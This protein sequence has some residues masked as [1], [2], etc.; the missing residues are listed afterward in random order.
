MPGVGR[1]LI[2]NWT[3]FTQLDVKRTLKVAARFVQRKPE[4]MQRVFDKAEARKEASVA[5]YEAIQRLWKNQRR[6]NSYDL[7]FMD[8]VCEEVKRHEGTKNSQRLDNADFRVAVNDW[9][10]KAT[11]GSGKG[12]LAI[13]LKNRKTGGTRPALRVLEADLHELAKRDPKK[14]ETALK[15]ATL[16]HAVNSSPTPEDGSRF[17]EWA[18]CL[19]KFGLN[20]EFATPMLS[21]INNKDL[22][23]LANCIGDALTELLHPD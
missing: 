4:E 8:L 19:R 5:V 13:L 14:Y 7:N 9:V 22:P 3:T 18:D 17:G 15:L 16:L 11:V 1:V 20:E 2:K 12:N 23:G 10:F 6:A 21:A